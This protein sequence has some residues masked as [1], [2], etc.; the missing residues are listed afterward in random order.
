MPLKIAQI[1]PL[2]ESVPPSLYGG[3][4]RVVAH[5]TDSLVELGHD[6]TLFASGDARTAARLI[7]MRERAIRLDPSPLKSDVGA[8]LAMLYEVRRRAHEFDI[9]HFHIDLIHFPFFEGL[10]DRTLTTLHGRLDLADLAGVYRRWPAFPLVSISDNQREPLPFANWLATVH[11]GIP[12]HLFDYRAAHQ[13]YLA[14]LGRISPEK[15]PDRAIEVARR[16]GV[17]VKL[18]A[19]VDAVDAEYFREVIEPL[20]EQPD[21]E[22]LGEVDDAHK[23]ELLGGAAALVFP[24]DW[25]E[26]FGL[27]MIEAMACGTPVIAWDAG[28]VRE[29]VDH[30]VTGFIVRSIGEALS[31]VERID[32]LDRAR[33]RATF[34]RRFSVETMSKKYADLYSRLSARESRL[35][36]IRRQ[37]ARAAPNPDGALRA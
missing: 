34:E 12:S 6:I 2:A 10:A 28:S 13:G 1:A 26:P 23:N 3:T 21:V 36:E 35:P 32:D 16:A 4:E 25:P 19:K 31:A 37:H 24:I 5:L 9:L 14:F 33:V 15:R 22:F 18:A 30:G 29:I 11:H 20:L 17:P 8:H 27:V 7:P